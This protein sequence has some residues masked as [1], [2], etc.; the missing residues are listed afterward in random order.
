MHV[1]LNTI[2][3]VSAAVCCRAASDGLC[4][5]FVA[6]SEQA[7]SWFHFSTRQ[8]NRGKQKG[9]CVC[10]QEDWVV[11]CLTPPFYIV[12]LAAAGPTR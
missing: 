2:T 6:L 9:I 3:F 1:P 11:S 4:F 5:L 8:L 12:Q 10:V 7:R